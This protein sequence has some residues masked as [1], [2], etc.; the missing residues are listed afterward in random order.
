MVLGCD[1]VTIEEINTVDLIFRG[2]GGRLCRSG[3]KRHGRKSTWSE[4]RSRHGRKVDMVGK[5]TIMVR[6]STWL[7]VESGH[8]RFN[9][10]GRAGLCYLGG[11]RHGRFDRLRGKTHRPCRFD[12]LQVGGRRHCRETEID[13]VDLNLGVAVDIV[14]QRKAILEGD[15]VS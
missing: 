9:H 3:G 6:K 1:T 10:R 13:M 12:R 15:T 7:L 4:V 8:G 11:N 5:S 2:G 14:T